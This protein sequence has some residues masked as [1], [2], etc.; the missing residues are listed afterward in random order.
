M[1]SAIGLA[2]SKNI[3]GPY[4]YE[5]TIIYS[6]FLDHEAYDE[7]SKVNKYYENTNLKELISKGTERLV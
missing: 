5:D 4:K 3:E 2:S 6:D 1:R 7:N